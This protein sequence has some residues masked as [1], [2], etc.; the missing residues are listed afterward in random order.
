MKSKLIKW[1]VFVV[2]VTVG[3]FIVHYI[4]QNWDAIKAWI[5]G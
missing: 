5:F 2:A 4:V 1:I 3:Y